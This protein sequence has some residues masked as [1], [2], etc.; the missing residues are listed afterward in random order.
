MRTI[1]QRSMGWAVHVAL[2]PTH[3]LEVNTKI[4][5]KNIGLEGVD[6]VHLA[7]VGDQSRAFV[8][9][10]ISLQILQNAGNFLNS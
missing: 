1:K 3:R 2:R 6:W 4:N 5:F 10:V 9:T 7:Q 8:N